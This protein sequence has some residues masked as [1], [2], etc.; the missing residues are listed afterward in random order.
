M[1][2][3]VRYKKKNRSQ[4]NDHQVRY[5]SKVAK[6][7]YV[8]STFATRKEAVELLRAAKRANRVGA[9][10]LKSEPFRRPSIN[11]WKSVNTRAATAKTL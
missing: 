2:C 4:G 3:N 11:G 7:G 10:T 5:P 6:S 9:R 8:Y 1:L